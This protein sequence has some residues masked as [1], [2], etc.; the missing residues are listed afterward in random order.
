MLWQDLAPRWAQYRQNRHFSS[1]GTKQCGDGGGINQS[2]FLSLQPAAVNF[3]ACCAPGLP[4][5]AAGPAPHRVEALP[6]LAARLPCACHATDTRGMA[7]HRCV[8]IRCSHRVKA[9]RIRRQ[10]RCGKMGPAHEIARRVGCGG[11]HGRCIARIALHLQRPGPHA[12][13]AHCPALPAWPHSLS[14]CPHTAV[15][16]GKGGEAGWEH[17]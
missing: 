9:L 15:P 17:G 16:S 7:A 5:A 14:K 8:S 3:A 12:C 1:A 13:P 6:T 2:F 11:E 10:Q 4:L